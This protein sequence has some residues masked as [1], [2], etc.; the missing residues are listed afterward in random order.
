M[1]L[2][3][4][5]FSLCYSIYIRTRSQ[6]MTV[7][8]IFISRLCPVS[9]LS[10]S[11]FSTSQLGGTTRRALRRTTGATPAK[12]PVMPASPHTK[13]KDNSAWLASTAPPA[14]SQNG[15]SLFGAWTLKCCLWVKDSF[16]PAFTSDG[17]RFLFGDRDLNLEFPP[18][19]NNL[20]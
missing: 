3:K 9:P 14:G 13:P 7:V 19:C 6:C 2:I 16:R 12:S 15:C 11:L 20:Y 8:F 17:E 10:A 1:F 5:N 4:Y 18:D